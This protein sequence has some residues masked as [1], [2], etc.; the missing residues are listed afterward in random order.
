MSEPIRVTLDVQPVALTGPQP[1][2]HIFDLGQNIAG[3]CRLKLRAPRDTA[4]RLRHAEV[5]QPDGM[6]YVT[7]LRTAQA[8]D[9]YIAR[10][11]G[12]EVFEPRMTQHGF[13]YVE[14]TGLP[15][16]PRLDDLTGRVVRSASPEVAKFESSD[17]MLN[18]I[19]KAMRWTIQ[20]NM[21]CVPT[22]CPQRD[23]RMGW[24]GDGQF[25]APAAMWF[26]DMRGFY[27]KWATD[28]RDGQFED[29][30]LIDDPLRPTV[31]ARL[32]DA[33]RI[34][35]GHPTAG[36]TAIL[37]LFEALSENGL[38]ADAFR[39]MLL[40]DAPS[41]GYMVENGGTT[42]WE[43][44]DGYIRGRGYGHPKMNSFNHP[45]LASVAAWVWRHI[46]GIQAEE[47]SPGFKHFTIAPKP[48]PGVS[49]I[50]ASYDT[51]R[52]RIESNWEIRNNR[53][54]LRVTIPP[55]TTA[56]AVLLAADAGQIHESGKPLKKGGLKTEQYSQRDAGGQVRV[57]LASGTYTF[58]LPISN[59][60]PSR[61]R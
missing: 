61:A 49:W 37:P 40:R 45:A 6:V 41:F 3:W 20:D 25:A 23:E 33:V 7:N 58:E 2:V 30:R 51:V 34:R 36:I 21:L 46:A 57:Q 39:M 54:T 53:F 31:A 29:G 17:P 60:R 11:G 18:R 43:R 27:R 14:V 26:M 52:G 4:V 55:N 22:D 8:I 59:H 16:K 5:L 24:T 50:K 10:G 32:A 42:I 13:R 38:H 1:G 47:S 12:E 15:E 28:I 19:M 56:T 9:T 35:N 44:W 48:V